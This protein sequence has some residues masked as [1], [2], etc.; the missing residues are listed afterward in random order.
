[1]SL[2]IYNLYEFGEFR[3]DTREKILMQGD[4][5]VELTPK[6]FELLSV[7][8]ENHG[9]L[10]EKDELMEK[11]WADNFVE[12]SN[13]TFNIRQLRKI[14]SD[15]AHEPRYI[16]TVRGHGYRFIADVRKIS[17]EIRPRT[18]IRTKNEPAA[19]FV[20]HAME[21]APSERTFASTKP[22]KSFPSKITALTVLLI[23]ALV[24][25]FW[26]LQSR[27]F[28][29]NAPVLSAPFN[30]EKLSTNGKA[31]FAVLTP[32]GKNV[33]Y[34]NGSS[35]DKQSV[36]LR[37][38][39]NGSSVEIIPPNEEI[40]YGL[41]ISPDGETLYFARRPRQFGEPMSI[42]RV[43]VFGGIPQKIVTGN[44]GWISLSPDGK[45]ISFVRCP[46]REDEYCSLWIADSADG[47]NEKRLASRPRPFRIGDNRISPDGKRIAFAVGQSATG[48]NEFGLSQIDLASG[49]EQELSGERFFNIRNMSWLPDQSGLLI[50][51][52]RI[53][54]KNFRIW[55]VSARNG[56]AEPLTK[57]S[58]SY[59]IVNL[60]KDAKKLI[61]TQV[62]QD[63][64]VRLLNLENPSN[65][66]VLADGSAV[67]FAPDGR[68]YFASMMSGNDEIWSVNADGSRRRQIT[69]NLSDESVPVVSPDNNSIF[70]LSNK[71]GAAHVWRMNADGSDQTQ[72]TEKEGGAPLFVSPGGE[73]VYYRHSLTS[74]LWRVS[75]KG[76]GEQIVLDKAKS[77]FAF[78]PDGTQVAYAERQGDERVLMIA[79]LADGQIVKTIRLADPKTIPLDLVWMPDGKNL[80]Y[81]S[82]HRELRNNIL[83][84]HPIDDSGA[85]RQVA[86]LGD[87]ELGGFGLAVSPDGKTFA[88]TQG[89]WLHDAVLLKGLR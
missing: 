49:E 18:L 6:G 1:M 44:E 5:P 14:L 25:G 69:N 60:D 46:Y 85:A 73:W 81:I 26:Y 56:K 29:P 54:N 66:R 86:A 88:I 2:A 52:S 4:Q 15:D 65:I 72:L 67:T 23:A 68:I 47:G 63:F 17:R 70:F 38:L 20:F 9:R 53:P 83:W 76:G 24:T 78:S 16:K 89:K 19:P 80:A 75:T 48:S 61:S 36:W 41:A 84:L 37:H 27:N 45:Q 11:I 57:D 77:R 39:E 55:Q 82:C 22:A 64:R 13:L 21:V 40:Y 10:L 12:E 31:F 7:L 50:T 43:P 3:L 42:Y 34:T 71:T 30:S 28:E 33:I 74:K 8:I 87:E 79:A 62:K 35:T 51:A 58:E 32:D 59:S